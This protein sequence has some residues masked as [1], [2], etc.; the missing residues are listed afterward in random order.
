MTAGAHPR[1]DV[2]SLATRIDRLLPQTQCTR[3]GFPSCRAYA[4]ALAEGGTQ[5]NR[6]PPGGTRTLDAL[7][8]LLGT[9]RKPLDPE[10]GGERA[11]VVARI[12]EAACIGCTLCIQVCPVD[13]IVGAAKKMHTVIEQEC[14]GCELCPDVCPVDCI[15]L[16][17]MQVPADEDVDNMQFLERWLRDRAP[18]A[19]R[20]YEHRQSRLHG[21]R[22]QP[23]N[24]LPQSGRLPGRD[25][26]RTTK[27]AVIR[28]AVERA[29][30]R[31]RR[32]SP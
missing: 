30:G 28:A 23:E 10:C 27:L 13:A 15:A 6:C 18:L 25:S 4:Q 11:W 16:V 5:A 21:A 8:G 9:A 7:A 2:A 1:Q 3:C 32:T 22:T 17:P 31:R 19:R 26:S 14:T 12:D 20:R 24:R 29:Q